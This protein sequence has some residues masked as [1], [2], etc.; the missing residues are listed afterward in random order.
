[1]G[2]EKL[3][4][5][6]DTPG[7]G[8]L[9]QTLQT[10]SSCVPPS[11]DFSATSALIRTSS[12]MPG[13]FRSNICVILPPLTQLWRPRRSTSRR[14]TEMGAFFDQLQQVSQTAGDPQLRIQAFH[15]L[16]SFRDATTGCHVLWIMRF[17][18]R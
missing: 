18:P 4:S 15:A 11:M 17:R 2:E 10:K 7:S 8:L 5:C 16:A 13:R 3:C 6:A 14:K 1:M 9:P 12:L